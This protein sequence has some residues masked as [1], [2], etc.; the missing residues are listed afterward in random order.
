MLISFG[1]GTW[2]FMSARL[3]KDTSAAHTFQDD[4]ES[5]FWVLLWTVLMY[6]K[7]T[8]STDDLSKFIWQTFE[9]D[10]Q[11]KQSVLVSQTLF[12]SNP[13]FEVDLALEVDPPLEIN[14]SLEVDPSL[15]SD[16]SVDLDQTLEPDQTHELD[17]THKPNESPDPFSDPTFS[18]LTFIG[19]D[20]PYPF[21]NLPSLCQLLKDL[22]DLFRT[23]YLK[24]RPEECAALQRIDQKI[25]DK[26]KNVP[27]SDAAGWLNIMKDYKVNLPAYRYTESLKRLRN[28][29]SRLHNPMFCPP[30]VI[31]DLAHR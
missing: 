15:P 24:P 18:S 7:S 13:S 22:A 20:G 29:E 30:P 9:S 10:G 27:S 26:L 28:H 31:G 16:L 11:H 23:R 12:E 6:S 1:Q 2:Q 19:P 25:K 5:S 4:L 3:V 21:P 17:Q 14:P 8:F